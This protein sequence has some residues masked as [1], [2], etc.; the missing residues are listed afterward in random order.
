[1]ALFPVPCDPSPARPDPPFSDPPARS[2]PHLTRPTFPGQAEAGCSFGRVASVAP[3]SR[4]PRRRPVRR[5]AGRAG[6]HRLGNSTRDPQE[7]PRWL[8]VD[9]AEHRPVLCPRRLW[10]QPVGP[11]SSGRAR[12]WTGRR[13]RDR[14]HRC[15]DPGPARHGRGSLHRRGFLQ[16]SRYARPLAPGPHG[17]R[18][19]NGVPFHRRVPAPLAACRPPPGRRPGVAAAR[20]G[21]MRH[22]RPCRHR[23]HLR[24]VVSVYVVRV[25]I[26]LAARGDRVPRSRRGA[27]GDAASDPRA[28]AGE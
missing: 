1:M 5:A 3:D 24:R 11:D 6:L 7:R 2:S 22:R 9:E 13:S 15:R 18:D 19:R 14:R 23:V 26:G 20:V 17:D 4:R 10:A 8:G 21:R 16:G 27:P 25:R 12:R 28:D